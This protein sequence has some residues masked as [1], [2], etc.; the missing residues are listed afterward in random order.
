MNERLR[1]VARLLEGEKMTA[2]CRAV[3]HLSGD[4]VQDLESLQGERA[5]GPDDD[6][7]RR[8]YRHA[9]QLPFQPETQIVKLKQEQPSWGAP[10]IRE[11]LKRQRPGHADAG[12]GHGARRARSARFRQKTRDAAGTRADGTEF[13]SCA[14]TP[15]DLWCADFKGEFMLAD[16]HYCYPLDHHR[17]DSR[18]L[19]ACEASP[20]RAR[21]SCVCRLRRAFKEFGL[22][23]RSAPITACPSRSAGALSD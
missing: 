11:R 6:R 15:N 23:E 22:P 1:F 3:R 5:R 17:F 18:Y 7:S 20:T 4:R 12:R 21:S 2:L 19:L 14:R 13:T 16:K 9:N 10:K 8:P